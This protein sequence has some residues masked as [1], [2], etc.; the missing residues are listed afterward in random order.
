M[1]EICNYE[2]NGI[3]YLSI[4][5]NFKKRKTTATK[6]QIFKK[7]MVSCKIAQVLQINSSFH[8]SGI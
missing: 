7:A 5:M 6:K 1:Q 4:N 8:G 2:M 3:S